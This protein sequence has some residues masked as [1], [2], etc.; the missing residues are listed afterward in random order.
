MFWRWLKNL[1]ELPNTEEGR[2]S[3]RMVLE[4]GWRQRIEGKF[5]QEEEQNEGKD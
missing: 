4:L 1:T 5:F 3:K 2:D